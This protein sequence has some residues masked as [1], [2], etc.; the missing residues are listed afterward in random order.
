MN[1]GLDAGLDAANPALAA[2]FRAALLRQSGIVTAIF[3]LLMLAHGAAR[4]WRPA[5]TR[6]PRAP[7]AASSPRWVQ[8]LVNAG[9]TVWSCHPVQAAAAAVWIQAGLG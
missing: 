6:P 3:I 2:A 7:V 9:G 8:H 5:A 4:R 1:P